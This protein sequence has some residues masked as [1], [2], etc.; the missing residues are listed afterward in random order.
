MSNTTPDEWLSSGLLYSWSGKGYQTGQLIR[1]KDLYSVCREDL[2]VARNTTIVYQG[3]SKRTMWLIVVV[4]TDF[5]ISGSKDG[6]KLTTNSCEYTKP[7]DTIPVREK[8]NLSCNT[9]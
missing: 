9:N 2:Q 8:R 1:T 7:W 4:W 6:L 5:V 3:R